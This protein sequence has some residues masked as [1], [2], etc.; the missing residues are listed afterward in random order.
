MA[1]IRARSLAKNYG[2]TTAVKDISLSVSSGEV[3]GLLGPNGA[4]KTTCFYMI[5]GSIRQDHGEMLLDSQNITDLPVHSR[6]K[7]GIGYLPQEPQ[8]DNEKT[9]RENITEG[10]KEKKSLFFQQVCRNF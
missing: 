1:V 4:G 2:G 7:I 5:M 8:L 9:V 10:V 6:G 3:V